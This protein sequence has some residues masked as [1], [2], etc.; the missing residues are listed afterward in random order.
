MSKT[1]L[2]NFYSSKCPV[3]V[4]FLSHVTM[5]KIGFTFDSGWS[6]LKIIHWL[7]KL[8]LHMWNA[9]FAR[10][11]SIRDTCEMFFSFLV[12]IQG[13][14]DFFFFITSIISSIIGFNIATFYYFSL[15]IILAQQCSMCTFSCLYFNS[16]NQI[17]ICCLVSKR[18]HKPQS[19]LFQ[20]L[21]V[22]ISKST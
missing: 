2:D 17:A 8:W 11:I 10:H 14:T 1:D 12:V 5:L 20:E 21:F 6:H 9:H 13:C 3:G 7:L 19:K 22:T 18:K 15:F 4:V 16:G